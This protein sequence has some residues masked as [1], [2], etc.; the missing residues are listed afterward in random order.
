MKLDKRYNVDVKGVKVYYFKNLSNSL[1]AKFLI[2]TPYSLPLKIR[3]E[4]KKI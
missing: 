4:I 2:D 3:K 1:K